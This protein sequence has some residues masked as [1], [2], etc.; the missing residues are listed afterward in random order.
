MAERTQV[1]SRRARKPQ[2]ASAER[3][4]R[5]EFRVKDQLYSQM[6]DP[7]LTASERAAIGNAIEELGGDSA[8][9]SRVSARTPGPPPRKLEFEQAQR[10]PT[11]RPSVTRGGNI[12]VEGAAT[13]FTQS[14]LESGVKGALARRAPAAGAAADF[15]RSLFAGGIKG[16]LARA[17]TTVAAGTGEGDR[18]SFSGDPAFGTPEDEDKAKVLTALSAREASLAKLVTAAPTGTLDN[19]AGHV[20]K[21]TAAAQAGMDTI[22]GAS[23]KLNGASP[24]ERIQLLQE[25][26]RSPELQDLVKA[27]LMNW[28]DMLIKNPPA[29]S[30]KHVSNPDGD[31]PAYVI[32]SEKLADLRRKLA[33][34]GT[35]QA[36]GL[37]NVQ[38]AVAR[39]R[40]TAGSVPSAQNAIFPG[41]KVW[42]PVAWAPA[43]RPGA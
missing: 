12:R 31:D 16:A 35:K 24:D 4:K 11:H 39:R 27:G 7:T 38:E 3:V 40:T 20:A 30:D 18:D 17:P 1:K 14:L 43:P 32:D 21:S 33:A 8:A 22:A 19:I 26:Q 37:Q 2:P 34:Y 10:S 6:G 25:L 41:V 9:S 13:A 42:T 29:G 28:D 23:G 15:T 36:A 5:A